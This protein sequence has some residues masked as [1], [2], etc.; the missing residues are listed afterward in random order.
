[1]N[2]YAIAKDITSEI[3]EGGAGSGNWDH[4]GRPGHVGGS[5]PGGG[6]V[7]AHAFGGP[8][9][10]SGNPVY[11]PGGSVAP[12]LPRRRTS[13]EMARYLRPRIARGRYVTSETALQRLH[14]KFPGQPE[15][16]YRRALRKAGLFSTPAMTAVVTAATG[17]APT[18]AAGAAQTVATQV[19]APAV[20]RM[21]ADNLIGS[22]AKYHG[23]ETKALGQV[24][25]YVTHKFYKNGVSLGY[26]SWE[27]GRH[28]TYVG[29]FFVDEHIQAKGL[30][31][32]VID[33][34][35]K[36]TTLHGGNRIEL[37]ANGSAGVGRY[38]WAMMGF[39]FKHAGGQGETFKSFLRGRGIDVSQMSFNH[40]WEIASFVHNGEKIGKEY[41]M[42]NKGSYDAKL[43]L[44]PNSTSFKVFQKYLSGSRARRGIGVGSQS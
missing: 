30:G 13:A 20:S 33:Q 31:V 12:P 14:T 27:L 3:V 7:H 26:V 6:G 42:R 38:A 36:M 29:G 21:M 9:Y 19:Q 8:S 37:L 25:G 18:T 17:T 28:L 35:A 23:Y 32:D 10:P 15:D 34:I 39:D 2:T 4:K 11:P 16:R 40:S 22:V 41:M 5:L 43:D 1:V 24:P 44:N